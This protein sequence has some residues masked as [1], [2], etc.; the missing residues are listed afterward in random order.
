MKSFRLIFLIFLLL[1]T[2]LSAGQCSEFDI[3]NLKK[4]AIVFGEKDYKHAGSLVNPLNDAQDVSDS[5]KKIGF[6]VYTYFNS[7]FKTMTAALNDWYTKLSKYE[8]ALF[9]YSGHG[10]EVNG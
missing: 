5:L 8:V 6:A 10:A 3:L 7:D 2:K 9:Y 1:L 4:V